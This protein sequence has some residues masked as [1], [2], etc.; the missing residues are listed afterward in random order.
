MAPPP[1]RSPRLFT[2]SRCTVAVIAAILLGAGRLAARVSDSFREPLVVYNN[3]AAYDE[4]SDKIQLTE[5]LA[6]RQLREIVRLRAQGVRIDAYVMDAYWFARDG[7]Y[8]AWRRPHW[9]D[10]PDR[11]LAACREHDLRPGLWFST[12]NLSQLD[13]FPA[14][15][16]SLTRE[17]NAMCLFDGDY[18]AHLLGSLELWYGRGVRIFKFDFAKFTAATPRLADLPREE[19]IRRNETAWR[20]ALA[21]FRAG[22]P[23]A[24]L[25][26]YNGYGGD[27]GTW[28]PFRQDVDLRW[29][30][31]F[32]SLYS[33]DPSPADVPAMN[34]A[35]SV[36]IF[37]DHK[38]RR[39]AASGVPLERIDSCSPML[40]ATATA[41]WRKSTGWKGMVLLNLAHGSWMNLLYGDLALLNNDDA[42]WLAR[43]QQ[44]FL[45][46]QALG[47]TYVIGGVPGQSEPY[48]FASLG[49]AGAVYT[50]VNPAQSVATVTLSRLAQ[51]Q[52][53]S[54]T[55]RVLFRD[56]GF[57]P[58]LTDDTITLGPEQMAV[59]GFGRYAAPDYDFGEQADI[60]IP[61]RIAPLPLR[62]VSARPHA[63]TATISAPARGRLRVVMQ[64]LSPAGEPLRSRGGEKPVRVSLDQIFRIEVRHGDR[65]LPVAITYDRRV[66]SG[67]SWAVGE[68]DLTAVN[69]GE[70]LAIRCT[71]AEPQPATLKLDVYH[72]E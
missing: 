59:V 31:V 53:R 54:G 30:E 52:P 62:N 5:E 55:G 28:R 51:S 26:A 47:R 19:I 46:L 37:G 45:P 70:P 2:A 23:D 6:L 49:E 60:V 9:P 29:L 22:H 50:V 10:G 18:L 7:G 3:W 1:L 38:V 57:V 64:Q 48:G 16:N 44:L 27:R 42:R 41:Y 36:D 4:L 40:G 21:G 25:Q 39:Y 11:W 65:L 72:V 20:T 35:R 69:P 63:A 8:R 13:P 67:L 43:A 15:E 12:N 71:S 56:A 17:R 58:V 61:A 66:W 34:F 14:W 24:I 68:A 33:G 32:D